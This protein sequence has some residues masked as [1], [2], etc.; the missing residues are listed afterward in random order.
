MK[1]LYLVCFV[2]YVVAANA[3]AVHVGPHHTGCVLAA[4]G[5]TCHNFKTSTTALVNMSHLT[6]TFTTFAALYAL[7]FK[8]QA[9]WTFLCRWLNHKKTSG[10]PLKTVGNF[11]NDVAAMY[12]I[13][14][15]TAEW[16]LGD[17]LVFLSI[18]FWANWV[19]GPGPIT[20]ILTWTFIYARTFFHYHSSK[21]FA[22]VAKPIDDERKLTSN[23]WGLGHG[24]ISALMCA[25]AGISSAFAAY[26]LYAPDIRSQFTKR[27]EG[28]VFIWF[29]FIM[30]FLAFFVEM[31]AVVTLKDKLDKAVGEPKTHSE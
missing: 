3:V 27:G 12:N 29:S 18:W 19:L 9:P 15:V 28:F 16:W 8:T 17:V 23:M 26:H 24:I 13:N 22:Y 25:G 30:F 20:E 7:I 6:C 10:A 5:T 14:W 11:T 31:L 4:D 1:L 21:N 2:S